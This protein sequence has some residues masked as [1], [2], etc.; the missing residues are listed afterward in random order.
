M[1]CSQ[2]DLLALIINRFE[3]ADGVAVEDHKTPHEKQC[4]AFAARLLLDLAEDAAS[5]I[6]NGCESGFEDGFKSPAPVEYRDKAIK[7]T[8]L[9]LLPDQGPD[10][11][12]YT[13]AYE[14]TDAVGRN[15]SAATFEQVITRLL[16]RR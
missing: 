10:W 2:L 14:L 4:V 15:V 12:I 3:A 13:N 7:W 1:K 8:L 5:L 6:A 11:P 16:A 9:E